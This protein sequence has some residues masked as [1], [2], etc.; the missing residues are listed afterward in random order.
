LLL[1]VPHIIFIQNGLFGLSYFFKNFK[2]KIE[3][4]IKDSIVIIVDDNVHYYSTQGVEICGKRLVCSVEQNIQ[5]YPH[6]T[7]ISFIGHSFGGI[8][9]RYAIGLLDTQNV[10]DKIKPILVVTIATPH[11]GVL[12]D[13]S[14]IAMTLRNC[15]G[16]TG[17]ELI[18]SDNNLLEMSVEDSIF[19][20][21]LNK[22]KTKLLYG[23]L[24][25]D[26]VSY[27][28]AC[29]SLID[30]N[31]A[32]SSIISNKLYLLN[33]QHSSHPIP[34]GLLHVRYNQKTLK[35]YENLN[36]VQWKKK[37][38]NLQE[39]LNTHATIIGRH[40]I[41]PFLNINSDESQIVLNDIVTE[42]GIHSI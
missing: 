14:V 2:T 22:F 42:I 21:A 25:G 18:L 11:L 37:V 35:I 38:L 36:K 8:I 16:K 3:D 1:V 7:K 27:E 39:H 12:T 23:N 28:S 4:I 24:K 10:F 31:V 20:I 17:R 9:I 40:P 29:I 33:Y 15:T 26:T 34:T 30:P 13:N 6:A 19:M 41:I 5:K 32:F